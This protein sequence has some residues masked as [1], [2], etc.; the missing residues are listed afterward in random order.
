[1]WYFKID[2]YQKLAN[3]VDVNWCYLFRDKKEKIGTQ[4]V[5]VATQKK[6]HDRK[7]IDVFTYSKSPIH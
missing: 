2:F 3:I 7:E 5:H 6:H 4:Y 1:M